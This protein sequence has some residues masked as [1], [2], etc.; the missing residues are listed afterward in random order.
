MWSPAEGNAG[1]VDRYAAFLGTTAS[2]SQQ[3][4]PF[5]LVPPTG[6]NAQKWAAFTLSALGF[7]PS[8]GAAERA[9][10][11][12]FLVA[13]GADP[14]GIALPRDYPVAPEDR[15]RWGDFAQIKD[16]LWMRARWQDFLARRY[17]SIG[18]L[19]RAWQATWPSF[20]LVA[21]PDELPGTAAA[22]TDWLQFER[23]ILAMHRTAHRF[24][25]LLPLDNVTPDPA[26]LERRLGLARRIVELEKPAHTVFDVR[27]YWAF[28]RVGEAR[29][30]LETQMGSGSRAPELVPEAI[31]GRAYVGASFVGG[32]ARPKDGDRLLAAC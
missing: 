11:I 1:L 21:L 4:A 19:D 12:N 31:L 25:V 14:T 24:S 30:G 28:F 5:S 7:V 3:V 27:F 16:G 23:Q 32:A 6:D 2:F 17:R 20:D 26:E 10:W 22:Q 13:R 18:K 29:L 9:R 8:I 15:K